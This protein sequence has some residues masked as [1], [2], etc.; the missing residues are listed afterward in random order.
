[1]NPALIVV[2]ADKGGVGK[3]TVSRLLLDYFAS[4]KTPARAFD[5]EHPRGTLERFHPDATEIVD[6]TQTADQMK[7]IDTL[8]DAG[9]KVSVLDV[10]AGRLGP[11]LKALEDIGFIEAANEGQFTFCLFHVLG[12]SVSSLDEISITAPYLAD[13]HYFLVKNHINDTTFFEWDPETYGNYFDD[14][15]TAGDINIPKLNELAYEQV[16]IAGVPFSEFIDNR[17]A[18]GKRA[19]HSF[20]L[21][22]YVRTWMRQVEQEFDRV[23]LMDIV[24]PRKKARRA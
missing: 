12:P 21:R 11:T 18:E 24:T 8:E 6:L 20:V 15:T 14:V 2:G 23:K 16:E 3:T 13:A 7:I 22:G 1:M 4:R 9:P 17:T 5:A 10:R 19:E